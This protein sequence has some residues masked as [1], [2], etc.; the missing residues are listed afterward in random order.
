MTKLIQ[1]EALPWNSHKIYFNG[2]LKLTHDTVRK[3][4]YNTDKAGL[5]LRVHNRNITLLF[6]NQNI[7]C[8]YSKEHTAH[9]LK[10]KGKKIITIHA[11]N[12]LNISTC[13]NEDTRLKLVFAFY[14]FSSTSTFKTTT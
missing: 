12:A 11:E 13:A 7:C 8:G 9:M 14:R 5:L 3:N 2:G 6:L 4:Y 1:K 10:F